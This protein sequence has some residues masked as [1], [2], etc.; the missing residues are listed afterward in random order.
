MKRKI[1]DW[2]FPDMWRIEDTIQLGQAIAVV[3]VC[4]GLIE[5]AAWWFAY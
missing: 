4:F 2:L 1:L 5:L 3:V